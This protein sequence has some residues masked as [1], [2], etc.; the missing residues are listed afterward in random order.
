MDRICLGGHT[1]KLPLSME[2][3]LGVQHERETHFPLLI[4]YTV[5]IF[6]VVN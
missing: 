5:E 4:F 3:G 6:Y 1:S 2:R